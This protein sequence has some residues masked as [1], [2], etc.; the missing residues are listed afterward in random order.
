[1]SAASLAARIYSYL[2]ILRIKRRKLTGLRN[3]HMNS[4]WLHL[5]R[6]SLIVILPILKRGLACEIICDLTGRQGNLNV[7]FDEIIEL[8]ASLVQVFSK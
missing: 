2:T 8:S 7:R 3:P 1:M 4:S 5:N 6:R